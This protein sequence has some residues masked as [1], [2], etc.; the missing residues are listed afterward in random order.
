MPERKFVSLS[1][2]VCVLEGRG[3]EKKSLTE[4][5]HRDGHRRIDTKLKGE[6]FFFNH[7]LQGLFDNQPTLHPHAA[8][9]GEEGTI[10]LRF[11]WCRN[12]SHFLTVSLR[13][14]RT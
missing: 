3:R 1:V 12:F 5:G 9:L 8:L 13:T 11:G 7:S 14:W 10:E 2:G 6:S 4:R